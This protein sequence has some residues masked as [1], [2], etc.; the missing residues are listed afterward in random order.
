V[1]GR[2]SGFIHLPGLLISIT[3]SLVKLLM[4]QKLTEHQSQ[5][6]SG[7]EEEEVVR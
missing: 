7:G 6:T 2:R 4:L 3:V 1:V 5:R